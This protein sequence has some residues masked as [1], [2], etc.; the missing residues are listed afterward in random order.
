MSCVTEDQM[1]SL[2]ALLSTPAA[3]NTKLSLRF[4]SPNYEIW[5]MSEFVTSSEIMERCNDKMY[6]A[7]RTLKCLGDHL[8]S[9]RFPV[10]TSIIDTLLL[11]AHYT[12]YVQHLTLDPLCK[13]AC[14]EA[15]FNDR[16]AMIFE[17]LMI[18][19]AVH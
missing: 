2:A 5:D 6:H 12:P 17:L 11:F 19:K 14:T 1:S 16:D 3:S 15:I 7:F 18:W 4:I 9:L 13:G 8:L 10:R